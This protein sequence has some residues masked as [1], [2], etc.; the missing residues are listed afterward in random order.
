MALAGR[1][2]T[3]LTDNSASLRQI[4]NAPKPVMAT[5]RRGIP[6]KTNKDCEKQEN[7]VKSPQQNGRETGKKIHSWEGIAVYDCNLYT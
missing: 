1:S 7:S 4:A 6:K 3:N 2:A 5:V